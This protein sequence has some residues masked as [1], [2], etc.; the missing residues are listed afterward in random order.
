M[1][2]LDEKADARLMKY[3]DT[4]R[5]KEQCWPWR[6][7]MSSNGYGVFRLNHVEYVAHRVVYEQWWGRAVMVGKV[8]D[9]ACRNP[10]CVN[11]YHLETVT[12][13]E[14]TLRGVGPT[15]KNA[16]K[17]HCAAG[18]E[19]TESNTRH[20]R[21]RRECLTCIREKRATTKNWR[22]GKKPST[23]D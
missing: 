7:P 15:A 9:H 4:R 5:P 19:F 3:A 12:Q 22:S 10:A 8:L 2:K 1:L 20:R 6:G 21:G 18:H 16:I 13:R 14:N 23:R 11:P 17:T